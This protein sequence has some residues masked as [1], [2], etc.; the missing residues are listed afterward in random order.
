MGGHDY[1]HEPAHHQLAAGARKSRA[2]AGTTDDGTR[3]RPAHQR[4]AQEAKHRR[5]AAVT[6]RVLCAVVKRRLVLGVGELN[7]RGCI[8][9]QTETTT[10]MGTR[11]RK[12]EEEKDERHRSSIGFGQFIQLK[13]ECS[14]RPNSHD[15]PKEHCHVWSESKKNG[16]FG[17]TLRPW[18]TTSF[19]A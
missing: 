6:Q 2:P 11:V 12:N 8:L 5:G 4:E 1:H 9:Y 14:L 19:A 13:R 18:P 16:L 3:N 10:N 17:H 15:I 7:H